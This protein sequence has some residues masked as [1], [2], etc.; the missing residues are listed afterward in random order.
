MPEPSTP[1]LDPD[2]A[3]SL[4]SNE[5]RR[6]VV[7]YLAAHDEPVP[8]SEIARAVA[9]QL[10][11]CDPAGVAESDYRSVYVALYQSHVPPLAEAGVVEYDEE[12]RT[13]QI[14]HNRRSWE[15]LQYAGIDCGR[16]W[17]RDYRV[18]VAA[19]ALS[20]PVALGLPI[21]VVSQWWMFPT[22]AL[23]AVLVQLSIV[24]RATTYRPVVTSCHGLVDGHA[25]H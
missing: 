7:C 25:S 4:L 9:A 24:Q 12:E 18:G 15:L 13:A 19:V 22:L 14:A 5:R 20:A 17:A 16:S 21:D 6:L 11:D 1:D 10:N 23:I 8:L 3:F 2:T